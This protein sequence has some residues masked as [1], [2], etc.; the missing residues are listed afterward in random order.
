MSPSRPER[1]CKGAFISHRRKE[2]TLRRIIIA[3]AL[4]SIITAVGCEKREDLVIARVEEKEITI[5]DFEKMAEL[6]ESKYLPETDDLEGKRQ[7]LDNLIK[8]E[9]MALK[10]RDAGYEREEWFQNMW[11]RFKNPFLVN[12]MMDQLIRKKVTVTQEEVDDYYQKMHKE[13]TLS[14]LVVTTE[15]EAWT[16]RERILAG[17]DFADLAKK[18]S[19]DA[20]AENGGFVGSNTVGSI[21]WWVEESLFTMKQGDVSE[22]LKTNTGWALLMVH[23]IRDVLPEKDVEY[24]ERRVRAIKEKKG[25]QDLRARIEREIELTWYPDAIDFAYDAL[26]QDIPFDDIISRKVT[27]DN[28]PKLNLPDKQREVIMCTYKGG[29][30]TLGDFADYYELI[31]LPE[32]PRRER[33]KESIILMMHKTIFDD[34]LAAYADQEAK[35]LDIPEVREA[36]ESRKEQFLVQKLYQDQVIDEIVVSTP[37]VEAYYNEHKDEI[38]IAEQRDYSILL[39]SDEETAR[40]LYNKAKAG[41]DFSRLVEKHSVDTGAKENLGRTG[42]TYAGHYPDYDQV[43]FSLPRVGDMSEPFAVPRGWAVI[44]VEEIKK[45]ETPTLAEATMTVKTA[46]KNQKA[47]QIFEEKIEKWREGYPIEIFEEN[48]KKAQL[49]RTRL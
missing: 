20:S 23:R 47:E 30:L 14:Q 45:P 32:R 16:L 41:Q 28:A 18:H 12:A 31:G 49:K 48:L 29:T 11:K 39:V 44:K 26:P 9:V 25:I 7:H 42:L 8:K 2:R 5:G 22:P 19:I 17:E 1:G 38:E 24:A 43:A 15:D 34:I 33:G 4:L 27:Y 21:L 46:L 6:L 40:D 3:I 36:Y 35:V 10:A 37:E 13:Y